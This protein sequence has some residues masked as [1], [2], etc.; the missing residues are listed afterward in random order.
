M[1]KEKG[2]WGMMGWQKKVRVGGTDGRGTEG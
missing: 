2:E 1:M